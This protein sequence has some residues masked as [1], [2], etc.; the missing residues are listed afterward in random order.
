MF[1]MLAV[2]ALFHETTSA[3]YPAEFSSLREVAMGFDSSTIP[4][5]HR[6]RLLALG[7]IQMML[8]TPRITTLGR[9]RLARGI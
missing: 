8:G 5:A 1:T 2:S 7:L 9:S 4:S 3:L 6:T